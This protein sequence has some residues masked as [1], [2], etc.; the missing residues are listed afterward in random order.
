MQNFVFSENLEISIIEHRLITLFEILEKIKVSYFAPAILFNESFW[1]TPKEKKYAI[2]ASTH[3]EWLGKNP[4][5]KAFLYLDPMYLDLIKSVKLAYF[6]Y[7]KLDMKSLIDMLKVNSDF[8]INSFSSLGDPAS[9]SISLLNSLSTLLFKDEEIETMH[10]EFGNVPKFT[11]LQFFHR[12]SSKKTCRCLFV[13]Q[14]ANITFLETFLDSINKLDH[15][16]NT[17]VYQGISIT[18][19]C[20][21]AIIVDKITNQ[22]KNYTHLKHLHENSRLSIQINVQQE[23]KNKYCYVFLGLHISR[24]PAEVIYN[25]D[26]EMYNFSGRLVYADRSNLEEAREKVKELKHADGSFKK[27]QKKDIHMLDNELIFE[28]YGNTEVK[29]L[30]MEVCELKERWYMRFSI[31]ALQSITNCI[32]SLE[33]KGYLEIF[34]YGETDSSYSSPGLFRDPRGGMYTLVNFDL[35][36]KVIGSFQDIDV[37]SKILSMHEYLAYN[38][39]GE[40]LVVIDSLNN[41]LLKHRN[42]WQS[43]FTLDNFTFALAVKKAARPYRIFSFLKRKKIILF[44]LSTLLYRTGFEKFKKKI[45]QQRTLLHY[46]SSENFTCSNLGS[47]ENEFLAAFATRY[48]QVT[49]KE[50]YFI[51]KPADDKNDSSFYELC[52]SLGFD[53]LKLNQFLTANWEKIIEFAQ[54][55]YELHY[56]EIFKN[57]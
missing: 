19:S 45:K 10:K 33:P 57:K 49:S 17:Q 9:S 28:R 15:L 27:F 20:S 36:Q 37:E 35:Y 21:D 48:L 4:M 50:T 47:Y 23:E 7:S 6:S 25:Y 8:A 26:G 52:N 40:E 43:F 29:N 1:Q 12:F 56:M 24:L 38:H 32:T 14:H 41:F 22:I 51:A 53:T 13:V 2:L 39:G 3:L 30:L 54:S 16:E 44:G 31:P 55:Q 18:L 5:Q 42:I 11:A 46:Y 34:D